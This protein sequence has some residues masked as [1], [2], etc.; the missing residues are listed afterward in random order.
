[1]KTMAD[2][3]KEHAFFK[4]LSKDH[5]D[6]IS[7]CG[8]NIV[9][10]EGQEIAKPG[11][12]ADTFYL[13]K[14]GHVALSLE[15]STGKPFIFLTLG[16]NDILGL[17]WLIPPYLWTAGVRVVRTVRAIAF[18]GAC[19]RRKC[20]AE[21][22]LGYVLMKHLVQVLVARENAAMLHLLDV[23]GKKQ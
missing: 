19:L 23:Y 6:F 15:T 5:L 3:I 8:K 16:K 21:P 11:D 4:D 2:I 20:D 18:D 17:S 14:E 22:Q 9:F 1:M 13:I 7:G 12:P 10:S